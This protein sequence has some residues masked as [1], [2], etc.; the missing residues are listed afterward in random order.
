MNL[1]IF[2]ATGTV[3]SELLTQALAAGHEV[4]VLARNPSKVPATHSQAVVV[5]GDVRDVA[6][7]EETVRG[8][9]AVLSTLGATDRRDPDVRRVG[10][11]NV[12][13]VMR[14]HGLRR[15]VV[16]GGFH[17]GFPGDPDNLGRKLILPF[18]R[19]LGEHLIEDTSAMG[20]LVQASDVDWTVV[21]A[22][23]VARGTHPALARTG[24]LELGPWSKVTRAN[25]ASFML[26]CLADGT[27]I[28]QAPMICDRSRAGFGREVLGSKRID[29]NGF[30]PPQQR[31]T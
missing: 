26:R 28:R 30:S 9:T 7:V 25:V 6:A 8:C 2:G 12:I 5:H 17:L 19:L 10:T 13:A 15:L 11:A 21:R 16:M 27:H 18:L 22:P 14:E 3:G 4:R 23:R 31:R 20:S 29:C 24:T 1:A